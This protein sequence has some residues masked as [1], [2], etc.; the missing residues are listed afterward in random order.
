MGTDNPHELLVQHDIQVPS[1]SSWLTSPNNTIVLFSLR[2]IREYKQVYSENEVLKVLQHSNAAVRKIAIE[3]TG[4]LEM[5][6]ALRILKKMY[7]NENYENSLEILRSM[8]KMPDENMLGFLKLVL[9][10]EDDVQLQIEATKAIQ[11]M[12]L[13]GA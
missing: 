3:V 5:K 7:K 6:K 8:S 9:D 10:K 1:F 13:V 11:N 12:G 4:D 2:M